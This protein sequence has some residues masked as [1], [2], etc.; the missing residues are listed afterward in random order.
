MPETSPEL[1]LY[2]DYLRVDTDDEDLLIEGF[3]LAAKDYLRN[4]GVK[5]I[6][7][8]DLYDVVV[9]MLVATFYEQRET[10]AKQVTIPPIINNFITQLSITS[11]KSAG[12]AS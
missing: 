12:D 11:L 3:I 9:K 10:A 4:A 1:Q 6:A 8:G 5:D 2:K 7:Q